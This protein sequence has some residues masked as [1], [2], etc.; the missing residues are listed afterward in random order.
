ME[1]RKMIGQIMDRM[2]G[3]YTKESGTY[4]IV[5]N[6]LSKVSMKALAAMYC[7]LLTSTINKDPQF[8]DE[9]E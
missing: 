7:M 3:A 1:K 4:A 8:E 6:G 5:E 9:T 2:H